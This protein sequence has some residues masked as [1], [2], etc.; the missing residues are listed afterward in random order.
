MS[1]RALLCVFLAVFLVSPALAGDEPEVKEATAKELRHEMKIFDRD[2]D[3]VDIDFKLDALIR[4]SKCVHK[5]V[6]KRLVTVLY[7][8]PDPY[9][10]AAAAA[11]LSNQ[12][13][14]AKEIGRKVTRILEDDDA[15]P[16]VLKELVLTVGKLDYRKAW[17][18][19]ADLIAHEDDKVVIAVF[20]VFGKWKELRAH[21]Q[22]LNFWQMYPEDG[23]WATGTVNVD[24]GTSGDG[25]Q[26]AAK[27]KW[28]AKYGN[29]A[30]QRPRPDCVKALKAAVLKMT[31][32]EL[33]KP[34]E[35][36]AWLKVNKLKIKEAERR[37]D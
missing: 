6:M 26:R 33:K 13:P 1:S 34:A 29:K 9:V 37:R 30:K 35:F 31:T 22:I 20:N 2:F 32:E 10:K 16:K 7:K 24:T 14:Y 5:D 12:V 17:E 23:R 8:D 4:L 25:D 19:L 21:R 11:G 27:R 36:R 3:T 15:D 18:Q 28:M